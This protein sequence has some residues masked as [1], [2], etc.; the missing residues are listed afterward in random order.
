MAVVVGTDTYISQTDATAYVTSRYTSASPERV[1]WTALSSDDKDILLRQACASIDQQVFAG[2]RASQAQT[3]EFPRAILVT[4]LAYL[5]VGYSWL[6]SDYMVQTAVPTV[7]T[8]AQVEEAL[9]LAVGVP[10]RLQLRRQG[11]KS[12]RLGNLSESYGGGLSGLVSSKAV[13]LLRAYL[14]GSVPVC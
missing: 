13:T 9:A 6:S 11:V 4:S 3:L 12:F 5:P 1:A 10:K 2:I 8:Q 7:V 14:A